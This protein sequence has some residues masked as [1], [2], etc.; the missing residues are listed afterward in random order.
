VEKKAMR[1]VSK[2]PCRI[3]DKKQKLEDDRNPTP[4]RLKD[5]IG[6]FLVL[7]GGIILALLAYIVEL[8]HRRI[9]RKYGH[10]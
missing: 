6:A 9:Q 5:L 8:V 3:F 7:I 4:L 1:D 10:H 2:N